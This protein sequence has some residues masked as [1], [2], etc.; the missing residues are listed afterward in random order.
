MFDICRFIKLVCRYAEFWFGSFR[1]WRCLFTTNIIYYI[2]EKK[3]R[4]SLHTCNNNN[5]NAI[6]GPL[7]RIKI[8]QA[9]EHE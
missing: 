5:A 2:Y 1:D 4:L 3:N 9:I 7:L 8:A 6:I